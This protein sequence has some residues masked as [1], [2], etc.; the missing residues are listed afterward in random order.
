MTEGQHQEDIARWETLNP[1]RK[2]AIPVG[3]LA[4]GIQVAKVA[5]GLGTLTFI[6]MSLNA[7]FYRLSAQEKEPVRS[8]SFCTQPPSKQLGHTAKRC[9][10][11]NKT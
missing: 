5:E 8:C 10:S 1:N 9:N 7:E 6:Y 4:L 3:Q 2:K 11:K